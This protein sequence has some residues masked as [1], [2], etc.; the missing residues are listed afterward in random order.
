MLNHL[1]IRNFKAWHD[2]GNIRLAPLTVFFGTNSSGKTSLHQLLLLLKQTAESPDRRQV[3]HLGDRRT[4]IDLGTFQDIVY[5]H[6]TSQPLHIELSWRMPQELQ[7][8]DPN[9]DRRY[10]GRNLRFAAEI[11]QERTQVLVRRMGYHLGEQLS[12]DLQRLE[13]NGEGYELHAEHYE[14]KR[15][16]GRPGKLPP[17]ARFYGFPD[18]AVAYYQNTGFLA[19]LALQLE[20]LLQRLYY[21]GPLRQYPERIY[22]W[23]G[24][25]PAHVGWRGERAVDALLAAQ[26]RRLNRAPKTHTEPFQKL[27]ARW[28]RDLGVIESFSLKPIARQRK[29]YEVRVV[30]GSGQPE[31]NLTDVGFGVSQVLPVVVECFYVPAHSTVILEQPEIHLHPSVQAALADLFIEAIHAREDGKDRNLQLII[32]SHSEHFL[33]RLQRRIAEE[34]LGHDQVALYACSPGEQGARLEP[35]EVDA[36]G[37]IRNWPEGF[38]GD[39]MGDLVAMTEAAMSRQQAEP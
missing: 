23:S 11:T 22:V 35:L 39:E 4:A 9:S 38:F 20:L 37:N 1:R 19:D 6:D 25:V 17:P 15:N 12:A 16:R 29:E 28:L 31:V 7:I 24:E 34:R 27:V 2:T 14:L 18:E 21:L 8:R 10:R 32:E 3:L 30:T 13:N 33:R 36:Y 5:R 26:D